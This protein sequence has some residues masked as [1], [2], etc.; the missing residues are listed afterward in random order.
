MGGT[1][2]L[3][4]VIDL[5]QSPISDVQPPLGM[6]QVIAHAIATR[7]LL[8]QLLFQRGHLGLQGSDLLVKC[9]QYTAVSYIIEQLTI[10]RPS[11]SSSNFSLLSFAASSCC[12][13]SFL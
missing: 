6:F 11:R 7:H 1:L 9:E 12:W 8:A 4:V 10:L 5:V 2:K 13:R 3:K